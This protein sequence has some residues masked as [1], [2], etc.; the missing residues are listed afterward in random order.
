MLG[1]GL[2]EILKAFQVGTVPRIDAALKMLKER[3]M[4]RAYEL[5]MDGK[6]EA[7]FGMDKDDSSSSSYMLK[8]MRSL[9]QSDLRVSKLNEDADDTVHTGLVV[10][11]D[12][13][14]DYSDADSDE[15]V[16]LLGEVPDFD[17]DD[18]ADASSKVR[19]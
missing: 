11:T 9:V 14:Y 10:E 5:L 8:T 2:T 18:D 1:D 4:D 17:S 6:I 16:K 3:G 19:Y 15:N 13:D 7:F 12:P